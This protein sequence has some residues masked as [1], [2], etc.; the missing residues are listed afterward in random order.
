MGISELC[1]HKAL[2][3]NWES[4]AGRMPENMSFG[5]QIFL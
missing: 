4:G 5:L 2:R 1:G 3:V